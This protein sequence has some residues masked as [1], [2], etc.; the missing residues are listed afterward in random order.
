M[1][2]LLYQVSRDF[3]KLFTLSGVV[4]VKKKE[5]RHVLSRYSLYEFFVAGSF[6]LTFSA[7]SVKYLLND[8]AINFLSEV[9]FPLTN[10]YFS[11]LMRLNR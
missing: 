5:L 8:S 9:R 6:L 1:G 2:L 7:I 4:G 11:I 3:M 10:S